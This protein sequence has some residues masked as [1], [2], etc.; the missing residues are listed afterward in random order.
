MNSRLTDFLGNL[1][2]FRANATSWAKPP[3][4]PGA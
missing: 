3:S 2:T 1:S 4:T